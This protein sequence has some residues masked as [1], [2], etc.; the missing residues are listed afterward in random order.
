MSVDEVDSVKDIL[1]TAALL[2]TVREL[3][4]SHGDPDTSELRLGR[5][6]LS[7]ELRVGE[8]IVKERLRTELDTASNELGLG[9]GVEGRDQRV[10]ARLPLVA[11]IETELGITMSNANRIEINLAYP[12]QRVYTN[13]SLPSSVDDVIATRRY[14]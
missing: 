3:G 7:S 11:A 14:Q 12:D 9:V 1:G 8:H 10:T 13:A 6:D 5:F 2:I 4:N